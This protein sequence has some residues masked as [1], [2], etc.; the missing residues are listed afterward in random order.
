MRFRG[1]KFALT[2]DMSKAFLQIQLKRK[3]QDVHRFLWMD[4][5]KIR[6]MRVLRVTYWCD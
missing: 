3:D 1:L 5:G 6:K 2:A 4:K